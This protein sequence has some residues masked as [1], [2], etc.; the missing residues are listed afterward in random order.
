MAYPQIEDEI[1]VLIIEDDVRIAE[2]NR[3]LVEKVP[4]YHVIGIATD[5]QQAK[6]QLA[7]LRP[8]LVLLD[9]YFP[10]M[11]GLAFLQVIRQYFQETD[12]IMITASREINSVKEALRSGVFDFIVKPLVFERL[13]NSLENYQEFRSRL[14]KIQKENQHVNQ[15]EIDKLMEKIGQKEQ[16]APYLPKGIDKITLQKVTEVLNQSEEGLNAERLAKKIGISRPTA[17]R[18]LE[19]LVAKEQISADLS[20][21]DVGRPERIYRKK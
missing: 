5:E 8:H 7:I 6:E 21:G 1:S 18:Y 19:Y 16:L 3:R 13:K 20:Y 4:G 2:I 9:I 12:V 17:R 10:D 15:E 11:N 14:R